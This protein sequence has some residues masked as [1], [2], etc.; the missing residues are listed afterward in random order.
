MK[1]FFLIRKFFSHWLFTILNIIPNSILIKNIKFKNIHKGKACYILGSGPSILNQDLTLLKGKDVIT[2]NNFFAHKDIKV[3]NPKYHCV[4]PK[5]Q[6]K[7]FDQDWK[8]W[9]TQMEENMPNETTYFMGLNTKYIVDN[10]NL[11]NNTY[12][13]KTGLHPL[14]I[15]RPS[16]NICKRIMNIP[17][18]LTQCL[19]IALYMGY[20]NIYL[21]GMDFSQQCTYTNRDKMRFYGNSEI[22][23]NSYEKETENKLFSTGRAF[24]NRWVTY[25]QLN[26]LKKYAIR[27][28]QRIINLTDGGFLDAFE[29]KDYLQA[30]NDESK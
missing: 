18:A 13:L 28:G 2:Q 22:T 14:F 1:L 7:S 25:V 20:K 5:Y 21:V 24:F 30:L 17:T 19:H 3:I 23:K 11:K 8:N 26:L 12:Y 27:N 9:F 16:F 6:P 4:V 10:T 29:R 15:I